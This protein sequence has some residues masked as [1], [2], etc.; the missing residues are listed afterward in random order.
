M[1]IH[2]LPDDKKSELLD[3]ARLS[4]IFENPLLWDGKTEEELTG[5]TNLSNISIP[6]SEPQKKTGSLWH[7]CAAV[8]PRRVRSTI[9]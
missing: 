3:L 1:F 9:F 6:I 2:L 4:L 5:E 7:I 8:M